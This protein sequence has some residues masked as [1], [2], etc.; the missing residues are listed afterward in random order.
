MHDPRR[1]P[2]PQPACRMSPGQ[3]LELV[4]E[5]GQSLRIGVKTEIGLYLCRQL[6]EDARFF[7]QQFT[8]DR[9]GGAWLVVPNASA[10]NQTLLNGQAV[11]S[12]VALKDGDVLAVGN[13]AR[14]AKLPML[15]RIQG[16]S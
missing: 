13:A 5:S 7:D 15:V 9:S 6:G 10:R 11:N 16:K 12:T 3:T 2:R 1:L 8:I 4:G 14:V